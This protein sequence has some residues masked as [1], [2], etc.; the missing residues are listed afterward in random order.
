LTRLKALNAVAVLLNVA[1][2]ALATALTTRSSTV[3]KEKIVKKIG[4]ETATYT[5]DALAKG[6][7]WGGGGLIEQIVQPLV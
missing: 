2:A 5:R 3:G 7:E 4:A 1:P 6:F